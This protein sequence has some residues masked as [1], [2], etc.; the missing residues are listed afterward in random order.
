MS[1]NTVGKQAP[2]DG[3]MVHTVVDIEQAVTNC[4]RKVAYRAVV[5]YDI[6]VVVNLDYFSCRTVEADA[7]VAQDNSPSS[8]F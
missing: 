5:Y 4:I 1:F 6:G 8:L 2:A 7:K 3:D